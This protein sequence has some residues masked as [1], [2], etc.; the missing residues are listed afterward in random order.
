[1]DLLPDSLETDITKT[2]TADL[3]DS[4]LVAG[5][6]RLCHKTVS[7]VIPRDLKPSNVCHDQD[8]NSVTYRAPVRVVTTTD[9]STMA[10]VWTAGC[11][12]FKRESLHPWTRRWSSEIRDLAVVL[13]NVDPTRVLRSSA[14]WTP[15]SRSVSAGLSWV[16]VELFKLVSIPSES[17]KA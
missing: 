1:M 4:H 9:F 10:D 13:L 5:G 17:G 7:P 8:A 12:L 15:T 3:D 6:I 14:S 16:P 2:K 11:I